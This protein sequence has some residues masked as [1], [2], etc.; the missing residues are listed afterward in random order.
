MSD[1]DT[2]AQQRIV[3]HDATPAE[4]TYAMWMH[5]SLLGFFIAPFVIIILPI[6]LWLMKKDKSP[7]I[8][9]HGKETINFHITLILYSLLL[10]IP[11]TIVGLMLCGVGIVVTVPAAV[12][13]PWVLGAIGV[14]QASIAAKHGEYYRYPMTMR[15]ID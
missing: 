4:R 2:R 9:D 3:D 8:D 15:F 11:A 12:L 13:L 1:F 5:L 10:W 14:V 6:I 7:F